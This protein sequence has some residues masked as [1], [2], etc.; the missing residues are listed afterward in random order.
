MCHLFKHE[1]FTC[2]RRTSAL[3]RIDEAFQKTGEINKIMLTLH[4]VVLN[5]ENAKW[6]TRV[7]IEIPRGQD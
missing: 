2:K 6:L 5:F 7:P 3:E 4:Y 1:R